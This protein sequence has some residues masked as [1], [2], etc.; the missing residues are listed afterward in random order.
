MT[1]TNYGSSQRIFI[2]QLL[3]KQKMMPNGL[4]HRRMLPV[5]DSK[6]GGSLPDNPGE[7]RIV[8]VTNERA[9]MMG[10]VMVQPSGEPTD[11]RIF[12]R[13]IGGSREDVINAIVKLTAV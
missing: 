5:G 6:L 13:V 4:R 11:Q 10:D 8:C 2:S 12:R 7:R 9:Q 3:Q 1:K